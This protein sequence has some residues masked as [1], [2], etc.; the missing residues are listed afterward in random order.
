MPSAASPALAIRSSA[1]RR[2]TG[3]RWSATS[4]TS[5]ST[6]RTCPRFA[7]GI[8]PHGR[9][10]DRRQ[11]NDSVVILNRAQTLRCYPPARWRGGSSDAAK[12]RSEGWGA[13]ACSDSAGRLDEACS[14]QAGGGHAPPPPHPRHALRARG[15]GSTTASAKSGTEPALPAARPRGEGA[16][17]LEFRDVDHP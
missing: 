1:R 9:L 16:A 3:T 15:E 14:E 10:D 13:Y 8:G 11:Q 12:L 4:F 6:A 2:A 5:A 17:D 7:A